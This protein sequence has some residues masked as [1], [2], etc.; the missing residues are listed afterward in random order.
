MV[1]HEYDAQFGAANLSGLVKANGAS[2]MTTV[3]APT[4]TVVGTSDTQVLTNKDLSGAG[5]TWPTN[6]AAFNGKTAPTG[7]VVGT[8]DTQSL[9]GKTLT[10]PTLV[11]PALGTP[12]G[13]VLTN[14]TGLQVAGG[15]T[16]ASTLTG[17]VKGNGTSAM[18]AATAGTDYLAPASLNGDFIPSDYGWISWC[19]DPNFAY[20]GN[21]P[22][23]GDAYFAL[24]PIRQPCTITN[25][26]MDVTVA[27]ATLTSGQCLAGLFDS[28]G[29]LLSATADQ[30][31]AWQSTGLK[32]MALTTP[33]VVLPGLYYVGYFWNGTTGPTFAFDGA[34]SASNGAN[35]SIAVPRF[36]LDG[37]NTG[38]T[39]AF[40]SP[41]TISAWPF[42][43]WAA[44]S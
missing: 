34:A 41:A 4:G 7:T 3:T 9:S 14:C 29:H 18:T 13:G 30:H 23:Q 39:T 37:V 40:V 11:T 42:A 6:L 27:G 36:G 19:Y 20:A 26:I 35:T 32:T 17:L 5:M 15:G 25:I 1:V 10:S 38:L 44:V 2:P 28:T 33:Q 43:H 31:T 21:I 16:G 24:L 22:A 8:T 12:T